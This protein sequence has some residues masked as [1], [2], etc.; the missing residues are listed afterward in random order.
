[1]TLDN[2]QIEM[3]SKAIKEAYSLESIEEDPLLETGKDLFSFLEFIPLSE[4]E[5]EIVRQD[6]ARLFPYAKKRTLSF[7]AIGCL[8][9]NIF[10]VDVFDRAK[11]PEPLS[12]LPILSYEERIKDRMESERLDPALFPYISAHFHALVEKLLFLDFLRGERGL[13]DKAVRFYLPQCFV[14]RQESD[15]TERRLFGTINYIERTVLSEHV[16][17][18]GTIEKGDD[19]ELKP[20]VV[21]I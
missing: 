13:K 19:R 12:P 1:M 11:S 20:I 17:M 14:Q 15:V 9:S 2:E 18:L 3:I 6:Y 4:G 21:G 5:K 7:D 8:K 16:E 10:F